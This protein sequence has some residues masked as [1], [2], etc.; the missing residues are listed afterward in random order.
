MFKAL[1]CGD[2]V[3]NIH[4]NKK[5]LQQLQSPL[6]LSHVLSKLALKDLLQ[7]ANYNTLC[8]NLNYYCHCTLFLILYHSE[9][10]WAE[11][12]IKN[13]KACSRKGAEENNFPIDKTVILIIEVYRSWLKRKKTTCWRRRGF[14]DLKGQYLLTEFH[15]FEC[16]SCT[17]G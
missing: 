16:I 12:P 8:S 5:G 17:A 15:V 6:T 14:K 9:D 3:T 13:S 10:I 2:K 11:R 7:A 4:S 1:S